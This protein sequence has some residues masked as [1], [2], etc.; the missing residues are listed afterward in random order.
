MALIAAEADLALAVGLGILRL[1]NST[2]GQRHAEGLLPT[3]A[4]GLVV[5]APGLVALMGTA[6]ARP[7][8]FGAAGIACMP[9]AVISVAAIPIWL[10]AIGFLAAFAVAS[11]TNL[12]RWADGLVVAGFVVLL[13]IALGM[14][15]SYTGQ[16][17]YTSTSGGGGSGDYTLAGWAAWSMVVVVADLAG[18]TALVVRRRR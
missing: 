1:A 6:V 16:Y 10:P 3:L 12:W 11:R 8:L 17:S 4:L 2:A 7:V 5:A 18:A 14:D 13:V 15:I 9:L